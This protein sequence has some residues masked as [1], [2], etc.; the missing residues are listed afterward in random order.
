[1][2]CKE[3]EVK[4]YMTWRYD[5]FCGLYCGACDILLANRQRD[6]EALAHAW[7]MTPEQLRCHGCKSDSN[8]VYCVDCSI[9]GCA[10]N[11]QIEWCV[12]CDD[13]P[14]PRVLDFAHDD[15]S[16]HSSVLQNL[17]AIQTH[18]V[19]TWLDTQKTRWSCPRCGKAYTW[20]DKTCNG[21]GGP[22][23]NCEDEEEEGN[24]D[25]SVDPIVSPTVP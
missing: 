7:K 25:A 14:C 16:H 22:L 4:C 19:M 12:H 8:A 13:Y 3:S 2:T 10:E 23:R 5:A 24:A 9:K 18:G 11:R 1:M 20:Y 21:C 15:C 6:V 17:H